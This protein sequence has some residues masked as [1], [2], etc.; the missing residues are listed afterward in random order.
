M[1]QWMSGTFQLGA[2]LLVLL[3]LAQWP[4]TAGADS[5]RIAPQAQQAAAGTAPA[6][7]NWMLEQHWHVVNGQ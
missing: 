7:L 5:Y 1:T 6:H 2:M 4:I 3:A